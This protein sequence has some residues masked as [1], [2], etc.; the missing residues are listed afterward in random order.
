MR[1]KSYLIG[2]NASPTA[3]LVWL[4]V[5]API[6]L[7]IVLYY[8]DS[9]VYLAANPNGKVL[10]SFS[11]MAQRIWDLGFTQDPRSHTYPLWV[12]TAASLYRFATG[13]VLAAALGLLL[14]LNIAMFPALQH[15]LL[16]G[17]VALSFVPMMALLPILLI[18]V[19]IG[20]AAKITLIFLGVVFF[21]TRDIYATTKEIPQELLVKARTLGASELALVYRVVLPMVI[22]RLFESVR[23]SLGV[24]WWALIASEGI[25]ATEGL[26]YRIFLVRRYLDMAAII[27]YVLWITFLAFAA[28]S[29][30]LYAERRLYPWKVEST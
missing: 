27:P 14:G 22:P 13:V 25:A 26:G 15:I 3:A 19:G 30:L 12:D 2:I 28:Y 8:V 11:M 20:D 1:K 5:I 23:Q 17:V 21:I 16:P 18:V 29:I 10:P 4:Y 7:V 24:A 9:T 6:A